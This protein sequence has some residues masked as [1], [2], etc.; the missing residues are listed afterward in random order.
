MFDYQAPDN[1]LN[2]RIILVTGAG[3][4]IGRA[5]AKAFAAKGA[6]VILA[7]RTVAKLEEVYDEIEEDGGPQPAIF[8]LNMEGASA[9]DYENLAATLEKEFGRL[10]GLLNNAGILGVRTPIESYDPSIWDQVIQVNLNAQFYLTQ[11]MIPLLRQ[12]EEASIV[13][14]SSGV[15]RTGK[16]YWGAYA[17]SKFAIEGLTQVLA[18]ELENTSNIRVNAINPGATRTNMRANA[19]PAEDPN[20]LATVEAI[21]PAYLYLMG[22]DGRGTH[23]QSI[24]AQG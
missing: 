17:V 1:L 24:D 3:A 4:G 7:G 19:Y 8:P 18:D 23:G 9:H 12:A 21:M 15:G 6:T 14:T 20:R 5:A 22:P 13:F 10:D 16:A 2:D 11:A